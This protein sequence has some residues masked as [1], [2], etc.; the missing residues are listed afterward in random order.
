MTK[1]ILKSK[2][3]FEKI[4]NK[5][6]TYNELVLLATSN[7]YLDEKYKLNK[8]KAASKMYKLRKHGLSV[9]HYEAV[10]LMIE[11]ELGPKAVQHRNQ[12]DVGYGNPP[13]E[14]QFKK[15]QSGNPAGRPKIVETNKVP[16]HCGNTCPMPK[17]VKSNTFGLLH[18]STQRIKLVGTLDKTIG[19]LEC[20]KDH[21][22]AQGPFAKSLHQEYE[23]VEVFYKKVD[24]VHGMQLPA[25]V[26]A[27]KGC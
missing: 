16:W 21:N 2:N 22:K 10:I 5:K 4:C 15:G 26:F 23:M 6:F 7:K 9:Q 27:R 8:K 19:Y 24:D 25:P 18:K 12:K 13:K 1:T 3:A 14:H 20:L 11:K 17:T